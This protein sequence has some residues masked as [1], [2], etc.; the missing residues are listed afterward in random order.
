MDF[1]IKDKAV[2]LKMDNVSTDQIF[3]GSYV[4]ISDPKQ[5]AEHVLEGADKTIRGRFQNVGRILVT[6]SNF[7]C[8]SSREQA[9][10]AL[11]ESGVKVVVAG[12]VARIWYR[13]AINLALPVIICP[14][15][16]A[17]V[18]EGDTL[19]I[20]LAAGT[21]VMADGQILRGEPVGDFVLNIFQSGGIKPLMLKKH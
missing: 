10:I 17:L 3:P 11:I 4:N 7:G 1:I 21:I 20:D 12:S 14:D 5:M 15:A 13:N 19:T 8:G 2:V 6:G 9:V 16:A 18:S